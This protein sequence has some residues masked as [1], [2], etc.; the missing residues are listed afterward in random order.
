[1]LQHYIDTRETM[2]VKALDT[3]WTV[4]IKVGPN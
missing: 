4:L 2:W 1:M 3:V